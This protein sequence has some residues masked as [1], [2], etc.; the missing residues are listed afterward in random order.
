MKTKK[1]NH[2][3]LSVLWAYFLLNVNDKYYHNYNYESFN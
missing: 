3:F 2:D 1:K